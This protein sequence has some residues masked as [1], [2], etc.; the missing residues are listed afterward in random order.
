MTSLRPAD[1]SADSATE[2]GH[3]QA[4]AVIDTTLPT[5]SPQAYAVPDSASIQPELDR[6]DRLESA[7]KA[8]NYERPRP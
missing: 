5:L 2:G 6:V 4:F 7:D 1:A 3:D 8:C